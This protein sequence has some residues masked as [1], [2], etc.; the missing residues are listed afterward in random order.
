[1]FCA[2]F[3]PFRRVVCLSP[4]VPA[5]QVGASATVVSGG[6]AAAG[7]SVRERVVRAHPRR[8]AWRSP[9]SQRTRPPTSTRT[10]S[11]ARA[12]PP[13]SSP[14]TPLRP[15]PPAPPQAQLQHAVGGP[16]PPKAGGAAGKVGLVW[17]RADLRTDD[18][19]ALSTAHARCSSVLPVYVFDPR[20][21]GK[22]PAG[23]DRVGP[24]KCAP[25]AAPPPSQACT[26]FL[27]VARPAAAPSRPPQP[28][29]AARAAGPS[30][31]SSPSRTSARASASAAPTSS[32][33][34]GNPR[35]FSRPSPAP[36]AP[37]PSTPTPTCGPTQSRPRELHAF[38]SPPLAVPPGL[39]PA[40]FA[41]LTRA[42]TA[43]LPTKINR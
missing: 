29:P 28:P 34:G 22:T 43:V 42:P 17:I 30:S 21:Y 23:F 18:N 1:M 13:V 35:R 6:R 26:H 5:A 41:P 10:H 16:E 7:S 8:P 15:P 25:E 32:S 11:S 33:P 31:S 4:P 9:P 20:E 39:R 2:C 40:W 12:P 3:A 27:P 24:Y 37:P 14:L 19:E 38:P 36:S